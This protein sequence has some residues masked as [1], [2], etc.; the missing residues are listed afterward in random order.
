MKIKRGS[1]T[2]I[3]WKFSILGSIALTQGS[4]SGIWVLCLGHWC[5]LGWGHVGTGDRHWPE[6]FIGTVWHG[7][8]AGAAGTSQWRP[9]FQKSCSSN[10]WTMTFYSPHPQTPPQSLNTCS[11]HGDA[12]PWPLSDTFICY[13]LNKLRRLLHIRRSAQELSVCVCFRLVNCNE[14]AL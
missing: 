13:Q 4:P 5:P 3:K 11:F 1:F 2:P 10:L 6:A 14:N 12:D 8:T 9:L 7:P